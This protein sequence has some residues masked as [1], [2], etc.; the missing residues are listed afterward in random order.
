MAKPLGQR[1]KLAVGVGTAAVVFGALTV[2]HPFGPRMPRTPDEAAALMSGNPLAARVLPVLKQTFPADY[3]SMML[4]TMENARANMPLD[5]AK[6]AAFTTMQSLVASHVSD[7]ARAPDADLVA[8]ARTRR[9]VL[10]HVDQAFCAKTI[11]G[12]LTVQDTPPDAALPM[13]GD[14][15]AANLRAARAGMDHPTPRATPIAS[16]DA[17]ALVARMR[18]HGLNEAQV[19]LFTG[20]TLPSAAPADQCT[21]GRAIFTSLAELPSP[22]AARVMA[23]LLGP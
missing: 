8:L 11:A 1:M 16:A 9:A 13:V 20:G 23:G 17:Q 4:T 12:T 14:A 2:F 21:V 15:V 7:M 22:Q 5:Q 3:N 19:A 18:A 10:D 6:T